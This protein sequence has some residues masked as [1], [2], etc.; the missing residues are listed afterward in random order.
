MAGLFDNIELPDD[1]SLLDAT[2]SPDGQPEDGALS[3]PLAAPSSTPAS[4]PE[5]TFFDP[6]TLPVE[7]Q[8]QWKRMQ[9]SFTK[10]RQR[11]R[12]LARTAT[13]AGR[14]AAEKAAMVDRFNT[15]PTFALQTI[16]QIAP[17][18][19]IAVSRNEQRTSSLPERTSDNSAASLATLEATLVEK[20]GENYR[21][22]APSVARAVL[23]ASEQATNA[24][25]KPLRQALE[26]QQRQ[27]AQQAQRAIDL[28]E[29]RIREELDAR[30]PD[31]QERHGA[32]MRELDA[33]LAS[34][35]L[36]HPSFG[37]KHELY[38]RLLN[39]AGF[40]AD[41]VRELG[42]A[43]A[44]RV[45]TGRGGAQAAASGAVD[46]IKEI[47]GSQGWKKA[48]EYTI[49]NIDAITEELSR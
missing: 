30:F 25:L 19:G 13:E 11:D 46:K 15:D 28:E 14:A 48:W 4:P 3:P 36:T 41:A 5:E 35:A 44:N 40:R 45:A 29:T 2:A 8:A 34:N 9:A 39:P 22:M 26:D 43:A 32:Q 38:L 18:L 23:E 17:Q 20:L 42:R 16:M 12:E 37:S 7:L 21:W 6:S 49:A 10:G 33:F 47:N 31:W 24:G 1:P 27:A